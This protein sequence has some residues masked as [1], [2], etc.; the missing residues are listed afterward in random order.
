MTPILVIG[1]V[2]D[3]LNQCCD[4][5]FSFRCPGRRQEVDIRICS[6][7]FMGSASM[8]MSPSRLVAVVLMRSLSSSSSSRIAWDGG[9][10]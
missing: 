4:P 6:R 10:K 7:L 8:P 9:G 5:E 3:L 2:L 1:G